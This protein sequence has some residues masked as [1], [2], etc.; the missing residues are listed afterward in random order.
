MDK[1]ELQVLTPS[2]WLIHLLIDKEG[3]GHIGAVEDQIVFLAFL[4]F[5]D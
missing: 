2:K 1:E 5:V 3:S 4:P